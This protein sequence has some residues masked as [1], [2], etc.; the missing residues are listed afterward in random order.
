MTT[1]PE[2]KMKGRF[3]LY[4]TPDGGFHIS[5]QED[6]TYL[7]EYGEDPTAV[8]EHEIQHIDIPGQ[9]IQMAKMMEAGSMSPAKMF[10]TMKKMLGGK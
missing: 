10:G 1:P 6:P 8:V 2:P 9:I 5:Y 3:N 7:P 4:E